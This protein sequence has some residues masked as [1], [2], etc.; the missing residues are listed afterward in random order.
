MTDTT[1][2]VK[3]DNVSK[4]FLVPTEIQTTFKSYFLN[5]FRKI[6]KKK[7][8]ALDN[9]NFSVKKGEFI[10]II[11]ENGSGKST[12]LKLLA[13]IYLPDKGKIE[14]HGKIVPFL[15]LGV[16]FNPDLSGREN[17]FLNGTILGMHREYLESKFNEIVNFAEIR[18]FIDM[19]LKNYSSGMQV[20]L[21]FSIAIQSNA[22]I[23]LLDEVLAVG[24]RAFQQKSIKVFEKLK[25]NKKTVFFVSHDLPSIREFCSRVIYLKDHKIKKIGDPDSTV[26]Q[27][28]YQDSTEEIE[29]NG[30]PVIKS[31]RLISIESVK[32]LDKQGKISKNFISSDQVTICV[33]YRAKSKDT[34]D[35]IFGIALYRED[36]TYIYG[37]NTHAKQKQILLKARG[38]VLFQFKHLPLLQGHFLVTVAIHK[39]SGENYDWHDKRYEFWITNNKKDEGLVDTDV[40]IDIR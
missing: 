31:R 30:K 28:I 14:T 4:E 29:E 11:G 36:G 35:A 32:I 24:D 17:I 20:R 5:P 22:D 10:G 7:F 39:A 1:V 26:D 12:L 27:Y 21:A 2:A 13:S 16:G 9:I 25:Q 6:P 8:T 34:K 19:P 37:T 3:V 40:D 15:E 33:D 38:Q 23:Y 18:K